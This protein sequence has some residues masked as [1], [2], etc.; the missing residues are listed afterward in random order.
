MAF[1]EG[2]YTVYNLFLNVFADDLGYRKKNVKSFG[3]NHRQDFIKKVFI[4]GYIK[5]ISRGSGRGSNSNTSSL[6]I[7]LVLV[8][9]LLSVS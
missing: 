5:G 3:V 4:W 2:S 9:V 1:G 6:I 7:V 8:L